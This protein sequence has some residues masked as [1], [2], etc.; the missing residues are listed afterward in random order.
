MNYFNMKIEINNIPK[1]SF[2]QYNHF[3]WTKKKDFKDTL[4][5]IMLS[6]TKKRFKGGYDL[7]FTFTFKDRRIDT[8]NVVHYSKIF[9]DFLFKQDKDNR[10]ICINVE[11]GYTNKCII[12]LTKVI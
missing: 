6:S 7:N 12:T 11:K 5:L 2:N 9:E 4:R 1:V 3:H 8:I 10:Q